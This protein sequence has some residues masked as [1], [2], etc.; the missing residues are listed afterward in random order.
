[1]TTTG[2][3]RLPRQHQPATTL[4]VGVDL[5]AEVRRIEREK[6]LLELRRQIATIRTRTET[7]YRSFSSTARDLSAADAKADFL[8][9]LDRHL[10]SGGDPR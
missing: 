10:A 6:V 3:I 7:D 8:A 1:M 4:D 2:P 9:I 5:L